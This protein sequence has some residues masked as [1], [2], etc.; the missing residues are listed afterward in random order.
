[1]GRI[2]GVDGAFGD[3]MEAKR[4]VEELTKT[5]FGREMNGWKAG[6]AGGDLFAQQARDNGMKV[7]VEEVPVPLF[8]VDENL[9]TVAWNE[10]MELLS[11]YFAEEVM[12]KDP[13]SALRC[14]SGASV[15]ELFR[16][17]LKRGAADAQ[18]AV[19]V[20]KDGSSVMVQCAASRIAGKGP[21]VLMSVTELSPGC[22]PPPGEE[23]GGEVVT[24]SARE[25]DAVQEEGVR[26]TGVEDC[27]EV[28]FQVLVCDNNETNRKI[29]KVMLERMGYNVNTANQGKDAM[30]IFRMMCTASSPEKSCL[31]AILID[32][33]LEHS[34]DGPRHEGG[35]DMEPCC[36]QC[37]A[38][39]WYETVSA[40]RQIERE[41]GVVPTP[42]LAVTSVEKDD[43]AT[44]GEDMETGLKCGINAFIRKPVT[45]LSL[46]QALGKFSSGPAT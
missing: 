11:G 24:T 41:L 10:R 5:S 39:K 40:I 23:G 36:D 13:S 25:M 33:E 16:I 18:D 37:S 45:S 26:V 19:L 14:S 38:F 1:M 12:G 3:V 20:A 28:A 35:V 9:R 44:M 21:A 22:R 7:N 15:H 43:L 30:S 31:D 2:E 17:A 4:F 32:L 29:M 34:L 46:K 42:I 27:R 6:G 8:A